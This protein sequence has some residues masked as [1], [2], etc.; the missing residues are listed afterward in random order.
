[1]PQNLK[2]VHLVISLDCG[3]MERIVLD[4]IREGKKR[5]QIVSVICMER[6][7]TLSADAEA[8]GGHIY[9]LQKRP[10]LQLSTFKRYEALLRELQPDLV[11][12]HSIGCL[13]YCGPAARSLG[14]PVV[15]TEHINNI[16]H[17]M[18]GRFQ[19]W[20]KTWLWSW[21]ARFCQRFVCVSADIAAVLEQQRIVPKA[22]LRVLLNGI[23]TGRIASAESS[24]ELRESLQ[25]PAG[26]RVVG[27]VGRLNPIKSQ[28]LLVRAFAKLKPQF[29]DTHLLLVGDGPARAQIESLVSEL[30]LADSV[31]LAGYQSEPQNY[32]KLMN[33][34]A[35]PSS[36]E[37]LPLV[38][39]EAWA[40]GLPVVATAVGGVP[41]LIRHGDNGY[42]IPRGDELAL[43]ES[44]T[45]LLKDSSLA[46][47]MG[48]RARQEAVSQYDL[49]RMA[50]DYATQYRELLDGRRRGP[51]LLPVTPLRAGA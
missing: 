41:D 6:P 21:A 47:S 28:H 44:L 42:L 48:Q 39:L 31:H 23:D 22:K 37:G 32:L 5:G 26:A 49:S 7:G 18:A 40:A 10:G 38:I 45:N 25:I 8:L 4:L 46:E 29:P 11:H 13:F 30:Q 17:P 50:G 16:G 43:Q 9:C 1:M 35:L 19:R 27:T 51:S 34:F 15:H 20:R 3:G 12:S 36:L 2:V 24:A 33:V 14:I